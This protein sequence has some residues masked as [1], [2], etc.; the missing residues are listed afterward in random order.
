MIVRLVTCL[1]EPVTRSTDDGIWMRTFCVLAPVLW[2]AAAACSPAAPAIAPGPAVTPGVR[3]VDSI[4]FEDDISD[5]VLRRVE[6]RSGGRLDTVPGVLTEQVPLVVGDTAVIG[7]AFK[8]G[9]ISAGFRYDPQTRRLSRTPMPRDATT[10]LSAP[11]FSPDGRHIAYVAFTNAKGWATVRT[12]PGAEPVLRS[13]VVEVPATDSPGG[14]LVRWLAADTVEFFVETGA[15]TDSAWHHVRAA[16]NPARILS[17][18]TVYT[19][20]P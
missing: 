2:F 14:N 12:W 16:L 10:V 7:F 5:G 8:E 11:S 9:G 15:T 1:L 18:D 3:L 19:F 13:G 17:A 20:P 6:V 4:P